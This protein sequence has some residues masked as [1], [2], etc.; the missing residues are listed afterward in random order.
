MVG[1][2]KIPAFSRWYLVI[3]LVFLVTIGSGRPPEFHGTVVALV[4]GQGP[5]L[6]DVRD[7]QLAVHSPLSR[8][9]LKG[10]YIL[11]AGVVA[12]IQNGR[13][14]ERHNA[15]FFGPLHCGRGTLDV[16]HTYAMSLDGKFVACLDSL[17]G[18]GQLHVV[19]LSDHIERSISTVPMFVNPSHSIAFGL[20]HILLG[21]ALDQKCPRGSKMFP[22]RL[23]KVDLDRSQRTSFGPCTLAVVPIGDGSIV[24]TKDA[25]TDDTWRFRT[26]PRSDWIQGEPQAVVGSEVLYIDRSY[27]L[28]ITNSDQLLLVGNV[29]VARY[30]DA[31][32]P[33]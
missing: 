29:A 7:Q 18:Q 6:M 4:V 28:R 16:P 32:L 30:T 20:G 12:E 1:M 9:P 15:R 13:I 23:V 17:Y 5:G 14:F 8:E 27:N 21:L 24:A 26:T 31:G 25:D 33:R 11:N 22:T 10:D 3:G 19:N 2:G